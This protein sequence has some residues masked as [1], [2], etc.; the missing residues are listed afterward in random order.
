MRRGLTAVGLFPS[1]LELTDEDGV[2][3]DPDLGVLASPECGILD[4]EGVCG[5]AGLHGLVSPPVLVD[6]CGSSIE[7]VDDLD[8]VGVLGDENTFSV[9]TL[10]LRGCF[11]VVAEPVP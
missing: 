10:T 4:E 5:D 11:G 6:G 9:V 1:L 2:T 7:L 3:G 8:D